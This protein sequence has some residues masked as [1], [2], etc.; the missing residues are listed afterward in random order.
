MTSSNKV[1]DDDWNLGPP[2]T[3]SKPTPTPSQVNSRPRA[4]ST[5][6][7][8][9]IE[10]APKVG[11]AKPPPP[12][13]KSSSGTDWNFDSGPKS[14]PSQ[15]PPRPPPSSNE[16][17]D[18]SG[19]PSASTSFNAAPALVRYNSA[20]QPGPSDW[21]APSDPRQQRQGFRPRPPAQSGFNAR[22]EDPRGGFGGSYG[23]RGDSGFRH[24]GPRPSRPSFGTG[25]NSSDMGGSPWRPGPPPSQYQQQHRGRS[26]PKADADDWTFAKIVSD[27][28]YVPPPP[29]PLPQQH[30]QQ[31]VHR[32]SPPRVQSNDEWTFAKI[33]SDPAAVP[34][35]VRKY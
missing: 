29:P 27:S 32:Q 11:Q 16:D 23:P 22:P 18:Y 34:N 1:D 2:V 33:I 28:S 25:A 10:S 4:S 9:N 13:P 24:S 6:D 12:P 26:P 8:W 35:S 19:G 17:W 3:T 20:P 14:T 7:D 30:H 31:P 5:T 21:S 15:P